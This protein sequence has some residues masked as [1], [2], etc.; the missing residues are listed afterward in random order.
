ML[1]TNN[2][3]RLTKDERWM[4]ANRRRTQK[5]KW[6]QS[7]TR[8]AKSG[9]RNAIQKKDEIKINGRQ[10]DQIDA[11]FLWFSISTSA[12]ARPGPILAGCRA[13]DWRLKMRQYVDFWMGNWFEVSSRLNPFGAHKRLRII[14]IC[15]RRNV[16]LRRQPDGEHSTI[17]GYDRGDIR[18]FW[19]VSKRRDKIKKRTNCDCGQWNQLIGWSS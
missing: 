1:V 4:K 5:A 19:S 6:N 3:N 11:W 15:E 13:H 12:P 8:L 10:V 9:K 17:C 7:K 2:S 16:G 14:P 18:N